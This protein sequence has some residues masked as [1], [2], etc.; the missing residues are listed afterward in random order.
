[1]LSLELQQHDAPLVLGFACSRTSHLFQTPAPYFR[2]PLRSWQIL[3]PKAD[4]KTP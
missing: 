3:D 4:L 1:M 2:C